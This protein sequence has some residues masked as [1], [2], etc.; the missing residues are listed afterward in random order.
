[1]SLK[2]VP[3]SK[4]NI[5]FSG[6]VK[7][8]SVNS[9]LERVEELRIARNVTKPQLLRTVVDLFQDTA[10]IWYRANRH[11]FQTWDELTDSLRDVFQ[12]I[13]YEEKLLDEIKR[14]TQGP[15]ETISIYI[16]V[17]TSLFSRLRVK[18]SEQRKIQILMRNIAPFYQT[19]L[20]LVDVKSVHELLKLGRRLEERKCSVEA[21]APPPRRQQ[22]VEP[23]LAYVYA[24]PIYSPST[25]NPRHH[26]LR[27]PNSVETIQSNTRVCWNCSKPGHRSV[28]CRESRKKHCFRCGKP[29]VT[30]RSCPSCS[31]N[32][33]NG[34]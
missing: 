19:Q 18:I 30:V 11:L 5:K 4:W 9:F 16:A 28:N 33:G 29:D 10:L 31:N 22:S 20:S 15:N 23:D 24:E 25:S 21:Y 1:M 14:R 34:R 3:V 26:S 17:M 2:S 6:D 12:P 27:S 32:L 7:H 13:D 8:T